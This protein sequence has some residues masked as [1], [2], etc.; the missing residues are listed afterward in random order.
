MTVSFMGQCSKI[1]LE[2]VTQSLKIPL[3]LTDCVV[4]LGGGAVGVGG[5]ASSVT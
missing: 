1:F 2:E 4:K 5:G 3:S